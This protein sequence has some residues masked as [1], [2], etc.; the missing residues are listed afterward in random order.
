MIG[1]TISAATLWVAVAAKSRTVVVYRS[2]H[3]AHHNTR[4][5]SIFNDDSGTVTARQPRHSTTINL[6][7]VNDSRGQ[8]GATRPRRGGN[9]EHR[10]VAN[11]A[12]NVTTKGL[13]GNYLCIIDSHRYRCRG[14]SN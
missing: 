6:T 11:V 1:A 14:R 7:V 5:L 13:S 4:E 2:G 8:R 10:R 12:K 9:G 3:G